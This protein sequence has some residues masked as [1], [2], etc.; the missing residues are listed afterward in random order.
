MG[1]LLSFIVDFFVFICLQ[2]CCAISRSEECVCVCVY[3]HRCV[4]SVHAATAFS[5]Q[6]S[7][8]PTHMVQTGADVRQEGAER[9]LLVTRRTALYLLQAD[10]GERVTAA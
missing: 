2:Y 1:L 10:A 9:P 3:L 6:T 7:R 4:D 5:A 8:E